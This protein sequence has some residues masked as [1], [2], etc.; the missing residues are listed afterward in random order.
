[1]FA[2]VANIVMARQEHSSQLV[3]HEVSGGCTS[4]VTGMS[5]EQPTVDSTGMISYHRVSG[6]VI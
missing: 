6:G 5:G 4:S 3:K 1:M 2:V